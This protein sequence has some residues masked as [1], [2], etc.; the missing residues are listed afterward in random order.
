[1]V[2]LW[3]FLKVHLFVYFKVY[4]VVKT[5]ICIRISSNSIA[6]LLVENES[7]SI[8]CPRHLFS[9]YEGN[10]GMN[11]H[12]IEDQKDTERRQYFAVDKY[13]NCQLL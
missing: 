8:A 4:N 10:A 1:M 3:L 12:Q 9:L 7:T 6:F 11:D 2:I 5:R 13:E